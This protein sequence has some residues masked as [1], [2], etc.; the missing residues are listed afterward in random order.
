MIR[1]SI[2]T[3]CI[4]LIV[5]CLRAH[6]SVWQQKT[7]YIITVTLDTATH[8]IE[9]KEWLT[10]YNESSGAL[11]EV[12]FHLY[13]NAFQPG[14]FMEQHM[15]QTGTNVLADAI[16][17]LKPDEI[18]SVKI[19]SVLYNGTAIPFEIT[20]TIMR[21]SLPQPVATGVP[22]E[23]EITFVSHVPRFIRRAGYMST[24]SVE[25]SIAQWYPKMC[26]YDEHGWHNDQYLGREFYG[27][28]GRFNV[29]ITAPRDYVIGATGMMSQARSAGCGYEL[30]NDTLLMNPASDVLYDEHGK[31]A[32]TLPTRIWKF[33][34]QDVH[35]FAWAADRQ[36]VHEI[37]HIGKMTLHLLYKKK[38]ANEWKFADSDAVK[39]L[40]YYGS[41]YGKYPYSQ[42]T[43]VEAGDLGMEYPQIVFLRGV[44]AVATLAHEIAH[45]WF[46]GLLG[47]N[48]TAEAW[49][50]EGFTTYASGQAMKALFKT[51]PPPR[52]WLQIIL[53]PP[54]NPY[55]DQSLFCLGLAVT[56]MDEPVLQHS[57]AFRE[58]ATYNEVYDK[59]RIILTMLQYTVGDSVFK[60]ILS[61]Y[62]RQMWLKHP[63][64]EDFIRISEEVSG[65]QLRWFFHEW[66]LTTDA[67][68]YAVSGLSSTPDSA[69]YL[70]TLSVEQRGKIVMPLDVQLT[71][72]DG[73]RQTALIPI[74]WRAKNVPGAIVLPQMPL[75]VSSYSAQ[76]ETP[77][78][79]ASV[80]ID[81]SFRIADVNRLNNTS[82]FFPPMRFGFLTQY[83]TNSPLDDYAISVAPRIWYAQQQGTK[84]GL[85]LD[86]SYAF[87]EYI[88][89]A[90]FYFNTLNRTA[91]WNL[92]YRTPVAPM[93]DVYGS[94]SQ[95]YGIRSV[96][97]GAEKTFRPMLAS[98]A[99]QT[100]SFRVQYTDLPQ[101]IYPF[102][103]LLWS[104]GELNTAKLSYSCIY[105][106]RTHWQF[107]AEYEG[108]L[109]KQTGFVRTKL[110]G[111]GTLPVSSVFDFS[112]R[113]IAGT[114]AER[115]LCKKCFTLPAPAPKTSSRIPCIATSPESASR[116]TCRGISFFPAAAA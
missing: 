94:A 18:G 104:N 56:G 95:E 21:V 115:C 23:F 54:D 14:S 55:P 99:R 28:Y 10:Y 92:S 82:G 106:G 78:Q 96:E 12:Y 1:R 44:P 80:Y 4:L 53:A 48:E 62:T 35:D 105:T 2:F 43:V 16:A 19:G 50:D 8:A 31:R 69:G 110:E 40:Q 83:Q 5:L 114:S 86:G 97:I 39:I 113:A 68:D 76:F 29:N 59:T 42:F 24:D 41:Q 11:K 72:A 116:R 22:A 63:T 20:G 109:T 33:E 57:D 77:K 111:S 91:D 89:H 45:Q 52:N 84:I 3:C 100:L 26:A 75:F 58:N 32:D 25:Y 27:E 13:W 101:N 67:C 112:M 79:V 71:Y 49:L 88:S 9:G 38:S 51:P 85:S 87:S 108:S 60:K 70:T 37:T 34:A 15:R 102:Y 107:N 7:D 74:G 93:L 65:M 17:A 66:L 90:D 103:N 36:F 98:P 61:E 73:T 64:T 30:L 6:A 46:Y 81:T 47:S